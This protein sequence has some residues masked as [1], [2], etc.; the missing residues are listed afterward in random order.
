MPHHTPETLL[1]QLDQW[2]IPY[3]QTHHAAVF[4]CAEADLIDLGLPGLSAKNLLVCESG[5]TRPTL[6]LLRPEQR[7]DLKGLSSLLGTRRLRFA[8]PDTLYERLGVTPGAVSLLSLCNDRERQVQVVIDQQLWDAEH[9]LCHPLVN[10]RTVSLTQA[11]VRG[12]LQAA[13]YEVRVLAMDLAS[14]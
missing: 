12:F 10:T 3:A 2:Q 7:L 1:E 13:G 14:V 9:L 6:V 11:G 8:S 5:G 4:T